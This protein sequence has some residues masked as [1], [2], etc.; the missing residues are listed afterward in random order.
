MFTS[1]ML[2][3]LILYA[4]VEVSMLIIMQMD[5]LLTLKKVETIKLYVEK[6][7]FYY[8]KCGIVEDALI[9]IIY[10]L[11]IGNL[12]RH[13][14]ER[15]SRIAKKHGGEFNSK[16]AFKV[17]EGRYK[18]QPVELVHGV[19][20]SCEGMEFS[21]TIVAL[22]NDFK[23]NWLEELEEEKKQAAH[24]FAAFMIAKELVMAING[25]FYLWIGTNESLMLLEASCIVGWLFM[26]VYCLDNRYKIRRP[27][28]S[29]D[30]SFLIWSN[31]IVLL[32]ATKRVEISV[33]NS[34]QLAPDS[35][36]GYVKDLR[37]KMKSEDTAIPEISR[38]SAMAE[39]KAQNIFIGALYE[40]FDRFGDGAVDNLA[41]KIR[42]IYQ[43]V[44]DRNLDQ[45][46][47]KS[48]TFANGLKNSFQLIGG[49]GIMINII[50]L[51]IEGL[52]LTLVA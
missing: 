18:C 23:M 49:L 33:E 11:R 21:R 6:F 25:L 28:H 14:L 3:G 32:A 16:K 9:E 48:K 22:L 13:T 7:V 5:Q 38:D 10:S 1:S 51:I 24:D 50:Q 44:H 35:M 17:I 45:I 2:K 4:I 52:Q 29:C 39:L 20:T 41:D 12:L 15:A 47:R 40:N 36:R 8:Y 26:A 27:R 46:K 34:Y 30:T 42:I 43:A 31:I 19:L 37:N